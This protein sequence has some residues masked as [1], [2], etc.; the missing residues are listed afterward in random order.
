MLSS[1]LFNE[2]AARHPKTMMAHTLGGQ[3]QGL[4]Q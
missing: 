2:D 3:P 1:Y 4:D